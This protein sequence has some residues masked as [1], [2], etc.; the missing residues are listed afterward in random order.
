MPRRPA[1]RLNANV[2]IA[3]DPDETG[4]VPAE[5]YD[6]QTGKLITLSLPKSAS[7]VTQRLAG[8]L[9]LRVAPT[10]RYCTSSTVGEG[11][12]CLLVPVSYNSLG[13][14]KGHSG[15]RES[16]FGTLKVA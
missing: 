3:V 13:S 12:G 2:Q 6:Y 16:C 4:S 10:M 8:V 1:M 9:F 7:V 5:I 14:I 11:Q 15:Q